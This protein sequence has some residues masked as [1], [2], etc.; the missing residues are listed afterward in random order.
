[1]AYCIMDDFEALGAL[2]GAREE[3]DH[4][5]GDDRIG[6]T[7]CQRPCEGSWNPAVSFAAMKDHPDER[8]TVRL[9]QRASMCAVSQS[10]LDNRARRRKSQH[11][12]QR[13]SHR[14][15]S[16]LQNMCSVR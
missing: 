16:A 9:H 3:S 13:T 7:P 15:T 10:L 4:G 14:L 1:M 2:D 8:R 11:T 12:P 6:L 5:G